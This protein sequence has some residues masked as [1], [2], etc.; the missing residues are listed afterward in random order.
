MYLHVFLEITI[1]VCRLV[2]STSSSIS[3]QHVI[4]MSVERAIQV[5]KASPVS[6]VQG[7]RI[8]IPP[9]IRIQLTVCKLDSDVDLESLNGAKKMEKDF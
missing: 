9:W 6:S 2:T 5:N 1:I 3:S 8:R 7:F 4:D